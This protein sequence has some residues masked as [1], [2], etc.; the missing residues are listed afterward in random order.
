VTQPFDRKIRMLM[1]DDHELVR[2]G[3]RALISQA[4][5]IEIVGEASTGSQALTSARRLEPDV[6]LLD[7]RLPDM[8]GPEVCRELCA[9]L[10]DV[11]VALL[12]TFSDD[13]LVR[14]CVR[15]GARGY[16]LKEIPGLDLAASIRSLAA[17]E[18]VIDRKV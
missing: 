13:D 14:Q 3:L 16:L 5:D 17:G 12:T 8:P 15:A 18:S 1:V 9:V 10:P 6:I 2:A 7:A 4:S 11:A